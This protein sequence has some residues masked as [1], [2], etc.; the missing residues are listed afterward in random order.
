L[1]DPDTDIPELMVTETVG[2]L[3]PQEVNQSMQ[4]VLEKLC[5]AINDGRVSACIAFLQGQVEQWP[6]TWFGAI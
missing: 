6:E 4:Q 2:R 1:I 5:P 3:T